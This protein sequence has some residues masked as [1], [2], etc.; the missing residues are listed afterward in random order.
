L[1]YGWWPCTLA[2]GTTAIGLLSLAASE[3]VPVKMF[4]IYAAAGM[5]GS[6]VV[7]LAFVPV[8]LTIWPARPETTVRQRRPTPRPSRGDRLVDLLGRRHATIATVCLLTMGVAA[9]GLLT[10]RSTV[11]LQYRFGATSRIIQDYRWLEA[12]IGPL[13]PMEVVV[14]FGGPSPPSFLGQLQYVARLEQQIAKV[15]DVGAALS[16]ADF[17]PLLPTGGSLRDVSRRALLRRQTATLQERIEA[18][19]Y[20]A[21]GD[22]GEQLWR[23]SLRAPAL[24]DLDYGRFVDTLRRAVEPYTERAKGVRVT[25]TGLIPL[26]YKAQREL[27]SDLVESFFLAFAVIALVMVLVL[28]DP[29]SGLLAM[30]PNVFPAVL[31]FGLMGWAGIPIEIGSIMTASAAMGI[32]VD[33]TFHFLKWFRTG[34]RP[35][36]PRLDTLRFA[37]HRC[38]GAM[39]HT[40]LICASGLLVFSLSSFMPIV[41]FSWMMATLLL[42]ALLGD[43]ILLPAL[44][45][46][47]L[48]KWLTPKAPQPAATTG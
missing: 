2:S 9:G 44:L 3:I 14:H 13:V 35:D 41:R 20:L 7:V 12:H 6:L 18:A 25:Y 37:F 36:V 8:A 30:V 17:A 1:A 22:A 39:V 23:I 34:A 27:L 43:L 26:I 21:D 32:A 15:T 29:R 10:L 28:R 38:A 40:T 48:G 33:D 24:S 16:G 5:C 4:G 46:G 31:I 45:V 11:K 42:A 47:P 19:H